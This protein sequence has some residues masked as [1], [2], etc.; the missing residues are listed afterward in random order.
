MIVAMN[1]AGLV[2]DYLAYLEVKKG[3]ARS[4]G[5]RT[6][7][8]LCL[9]RMLWGAEALEDV[10]PEWVEERMRELLHLPV[11]L[12]RTGGRIVTVSRNTIDTHR[13]ILGTFFRWVVRKKRLLLTNPVDFVDPLEREDSRGSSRA[14]SAVELAAFWLAVPL[15]RKLVYTTWTMTGLRP[16]ESRRLPWKEVI[17]DPAEGGPPHLL[18]RCSVT[19]NGRRERQPL[20]PQLAAMLREE[21]LRSPT[22]EHVFPTLPTCDT[23]NDDLRAAGLWGGRETAEGRLSRYSLRKTFITALTM[24]EKHAQVA[25]KLARHSDP[26]L[27]FG[28]YTTVDL[29]RKAEA[30]LALGVLLPLGYD[31]ACE[32]MPA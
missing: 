22:T 27:T 1:L 2:E 12:Q 11:P 10:T 25:H 13:S 29:R 18:L 6:R 14:F 24:D 9:D 4:T 30:V 5:H 32:K 28:T 20:H 16:T 19:K 7:V 23:F 21:R 26:K 15:S 3:R 31:P 17:L 8:R